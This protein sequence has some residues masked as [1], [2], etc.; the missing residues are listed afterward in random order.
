M[1]QF[2]MGFA[3]GRPTE[4]GRR[5][6]QSQIECQALIRMVS[7]LFTQD[8]DLCLH[9]VTWS[10][11]PTGLALK[12]SHS[13]K[14]SWKNSLVKYQKWSW[15]S[16][17]I[18]GD[19]G[20]SNTSYSLVILYMS[21]LVLVLRWRYSILAFFRAV[22]ASEELRTRPCAVAFEAAIAYEP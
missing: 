14:Q 18:D 20:T 6:M 9:L 21:A 8:P 4:T 7:S 15:W 5:S 12:C 17:S 16:S 2:A 11:P 1:V 19:R 13:M 10:T 22:L 3:F